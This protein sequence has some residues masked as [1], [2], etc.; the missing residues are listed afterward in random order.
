MP[1]PLRQLHFHLLKQPF[2]IGDTI[3][4]QIVKQMNMTQSVAIFGSYIMKAMKK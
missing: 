4:I 3:R 1:K 2:S